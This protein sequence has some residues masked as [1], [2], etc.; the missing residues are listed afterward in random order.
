[1]PWVL[2]AGWEAMEWAREHRLAMS[3][4]VCGCAAASLSKPWRM[5]CTF[6]GRPTVIMNRAKRCLIF[7]SWEES[8]RSLA[9]RRETLSAYLEHPEQSAGWRLP[10]RAPKRAAENPGSLGKLQPDEKSLIALY[11]LCDAQGR[12]TL[13]EA[14]REQSSRSNQKK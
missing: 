9:S 13:V 10:Q 1:M 4:V 14:A 5:H 2:S 3:S 6:I 11:R 8:P 7:S 12:K